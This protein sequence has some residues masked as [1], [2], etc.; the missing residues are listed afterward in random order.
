MTIRTNYL[1]PPIPLRCFDWSAIDADTYDGATDSPNRHQIG[2]GKTENEAIE[3][4]K[5]QLD[6]FEGHGVREAIFCRPNS[7]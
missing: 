2:Y 6:L 5:E 7:Q 4:L 3:N 1:H